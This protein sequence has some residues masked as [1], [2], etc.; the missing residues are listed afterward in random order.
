ME[1]I[2][3]LR[4]N[5]GNRRSFLRRWRYVNTLQT[6]LSI[7]TQPRITLS[8]PINRQRLPF[9]PEPK[10][11]LLTSTQ[12]YPKPL[13]FA[14]YHAIYSS[15]SLLGSTNRPTPH[16]RNPTQIRR[17]LELCTYSWKILIE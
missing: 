15:S 3:H 16:R 6:T 14:I 13:T 1:R 8:T 5:M 10:T 4:S 11:P 17:P 7:V 12:L 2:S 9:I